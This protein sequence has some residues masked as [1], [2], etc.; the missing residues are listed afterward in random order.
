MEQQQVIEVIKKVF[1]EYDN[2]K[3]RLAYILATAKHE[4]NLI[5]KEEK[6]AKVGTELYKIQSRYWGWHGRG[7]VQ[8][9]W[10]SNYEKFSR[11]LGVDLV[12]NPNLLITDLEISAKTLVIG[13]LRGEFTGKKLSNYIGKKADYFNARK[14]VNG[15][16]RAALIAKYALEYVAIL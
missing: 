14:T 13:M 1:Y 7:L 11:I 5:P 10:K 3:R 16:D 12:A 4:C 15:L 8:L 9:T 2:D 6:R